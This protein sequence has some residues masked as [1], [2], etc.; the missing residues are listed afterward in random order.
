MWICSATD[1]MQNKYIAYFF[2]A[3]LSVFLLISLRF[4]CVCLYIVQWRC[5]FNEIPKRHPKAR[6]IKPYLICASVAD[7][8]KMFAMNQLK[9]GTCY[10]F[11]FVVVVDGGFASILCIVPCLNRTN[12]YICDE[13][14]VMLI[15][16]NE[17]K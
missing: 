15:K 8:F 13:W 12:S 3:S 5:G 11:H 4:F 9:P 7:W 6:G 10:M 17:M 2:G 14:N 1:K 16:W